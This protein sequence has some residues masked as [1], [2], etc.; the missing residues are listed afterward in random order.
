MRVND[1]YNNVNTNT[2]SLNNDTSAAAFFTEGS[3]VEGVVTE[4]DDK[5]ATVLFENRKDIAASFDGNKNVTRTLTFPSENIKDAEVGQLRKFRVLSS[6]SD[7]IVLKD[8][9]FDKKEGAVSKMS[10]MDIDPSLP[11]MLE[12]FEE[13]NGTKEKE[14]RDN[15]RNLSDEDYSALKKEGMDLEKFASERLEKAIERI[16]FMR[17]F[18]AEVLE[19][20]IETRRNEEKALTEA[21]VKKVSKNPAQERIARALA[22]ADLPVTAENVEALEQTSEQFNSISRLSANSIFFLVKN[23]AVPSLSNVYRAEYAGAAT[24]TPIA[25]N[26]WKQLEND[27]AE[28]AAGAAEEL[29]VLSQEKGDTIIDVNLNDAKRLLEHDI[30][31]TRENLVYMKQLESLECTEEMTIKAGIRAMKQGKRPDEGLLLDTEAEREERLTAEV[32]NAV[33]MTDSISDS[34]IRIYFRRNEMEIHPSLQNLSEA[35]KEI[36]ENPSVQ[37]NLT[38]GMSIREINTKLMLEEIR[39][40]MTA[41]SG[42]RLLAK[43]ISIATDNLEKVVD[44]LRET[45]RE[46]YRNLFESGNGKEMQNVSGLEAP[47]HIYGEVNESLHSVE[48]A[49][50]QLLG[51]TYSERHGITLQALA[52]RG[53]ELRVRFLE[54]GTEF[55]R[56]GNGN[57]ALTRASEAY[58]AGATEIRKDLGDSI[59]KAFANMDSLLEEN[60][61]ELTEA[62]RRAVRILGYNSIEINQENIDNIKYYDAK[63]SGL[64]EKMTPQVVL[65]MVERGINPLDMDIDSLAGLVRGIRNEIGKTTEE[66]FSSFLVRMEE[67]GA[68]TEAE[69]SS[70]IGIYRMLYQLEKNDGAALGAAVRSGKELT[71]G[72]LMAELRSSKRN[73]NVEINDTSEPAQTRYVNSITDQISEASG[74]YN[75]EKTDSYSERTAYVA[76]LADKILDNT[77]PEQWKSALNG[78]DPEK[79]T[80]ESFAERLEAVGTEKLPDDAA[81]DGEY[82]TT[83]VE[84][85]RIRTIMDSNEGIK[86]FLNAFNVPDS[87]SNITACVDELNMLPENR[88]RENEKNKTGITLERDELL[89]GLEGESELDEL[90]GI[91]T[92]LANSLI[93]QAFETSANAIS[94]RS[95][96]EQADRLGLL[97]RLG[98]NGHFRFTVSDEEKKANINLTIIRNTGNAGTLS[99]QLKTEEYSMTS[100][101]SLV[102]MESSYDGGSVTEPMMTGQ[103]YCDSREALPELN[104]KLAG[105]REA[106][107]AAG[108]VPGDIK[109]AQGSESTSRYIGRLAAAKKGEDRKNNVSTGTL[110]RAA[111][112]FV[113]AFI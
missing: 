28:I 51:D 29:A 35:Q 2:I 56:I 101:L 47:D 78:R 82:D 50:V 24:Y 67:S 95:L 60:G 84:A 100:D 99:I 48:E 102:L 32:R 4:C 9:T 40:S 71:F 98:S 8:I 68:V 112:S 53:R 10:I 46:M 38:G 97:G 20:N 86:N 107:A 3:V 61:I 106:L 7:K 19:N 58:E 64:V 52:E 57:P 49:P 109:L 94:A 96:T 1:L 111:R 79:V 39:L 59:R 37:A 41:E 87:V 26:D 25:E 33:R 54:A 88:E 83:G 69:R 45:Q 16:K 104:G 6:S 31:L 23:E 42:R 89:S 103:I 70:Y 66:K 13:V 43:G 72:N 85:D 75:K 93:G 105:F 90:L 81:V 110:Y 55:E 36:D 11:Q 73:I 12:D 74:R 77:A 63:V 34:A 44:A 80:I 5:K 62:N 22:E 108:I 65:E 91:K 21:A 113:A 14:D 92:R 30:P 18:K 17:S 15:I 27:A 76:S